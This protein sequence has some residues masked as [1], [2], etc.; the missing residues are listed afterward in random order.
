VVVVFLVAVFLV[1]GWLLSL[2]L[3]LRLG[4]ADLLWLVTTF[5]LWFVMIWVLPAAR[6][7][8]VPVTLV[9]S[10]TATNISATAIIKSATAFVII[11]RAT[12]PDFIM[13]S[14]AGCSPA[15]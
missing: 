8:S 15:R 5:N 10:A 14:R 1:S 4:A 7:L 9:I 3:A 11:M 12:I 13:N 2:G 6:F